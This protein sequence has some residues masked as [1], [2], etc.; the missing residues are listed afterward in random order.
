MDPHWN[1]S[2]P[3]SRWGCEQDS[4]WSGPADFK[5]DGWQWARGVYLSFE[6]VKRAEFNLVNIHDSSKLF[7]VADGEYLRFED[8]NDKERKRDDCQ[9]KLNLYR[10]FRPNPG[11]AVML[12]VSSKGE[13]MIICCCENGGEKIVYL[14]P[15]VRDLPTWIP[16]SSHE[17]LFLLIKLKGGNCV[18]LKSSQW[19][20]WVLT[21]KAEGDG[22]VKL[23]LT[24]D[25]EDGED[26]LYLL[27]SEI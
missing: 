3:G 20:K 24:E 4:V 23:V 11:S 5:F 14:K 21:S 13:N 12:T 2:H 26:E 16:N 17:A 1:P 15:Q 18:K 7:L 25:R 9:F 27:N 6:D 19:P 8:R 22:H 10:D